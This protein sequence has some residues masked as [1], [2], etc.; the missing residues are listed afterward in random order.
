M[1]GDRQDAHDQGVFRAPRVIDAQI[2]Q[3]LPTR[4]V[5][6]ERSK[7]DV[8]VPG[9]ELEPVGLR[10]EVDVVILSGPEK[11]V[12]ITEQ[13]IDCQKSE[14]L[15][16][17]EVGYQL[18]S[19][20]LIV[21]LMKESGE[22]DHALLLLRGRRGF[23][24][25]GGFVFGPIL[26]EITK[27]AE[28]AR[29]EQQA[30]CTSVAVFQ[31]SFVDLFDECVQAHWLLIDG[32]G[33]CQAHLRK[34]NTRTVDARLPEQR[35]RQWF[36]QKGRIGDVVVEIDFGEATEFDVVPEFM[37]VDLEGK[38]PAVVGC[39]ERAVPLVP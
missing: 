20:G 11:T 25:V 6:R 22:F 38:F 12:E 28:G 39:Q 24:N 33:D 4:F 1:A 5:L 31:K 37:E 19:E 10:L 3:L 8:Q 14:E 30:L 2:G 26:T 29:F 27:H 15:V 13:H 18:V 9:E 21:A 36:A 16:D 17:V 34:T 23:G 7:G 32:S 35:I